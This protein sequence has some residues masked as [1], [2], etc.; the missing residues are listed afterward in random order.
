P[1]DR[2][3]FLTPATDE[4]LIQRALDGSQRAWVKLVERHERLV[5]NYCLRQTRNRSDAMDLLQEVF[6]AVYRHLPSYR[7]DGEFPAWMMRIAVNKTMD[8][9]RQHQRSPQLDTDENAEAAM[10]DSP[11]PDEHGPELSIE[12]HYDNRMIHALLLQLP[13]EQRLVV[14]LKFF[15]HYTFE[16][17]GQQTGVA[18][19]TVKSRFYA[20]LAK[21]KDHMEAQHVQ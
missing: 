17:I 2:R 3:M 6:L 12:R 19:N 20:S 16:Q 21:L 18:V 4:V 1:G 8:H 5:F 13:L 7:G 11:A 15:Q 14:E 10:L 9:W